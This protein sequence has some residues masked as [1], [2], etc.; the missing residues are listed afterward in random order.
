MT[1][2]HGVSVPCDPGSTPTLPI[3]F[4]GIEV[5]DEYGWRQ[6]ILD[7]RRDFTD[8]NWHM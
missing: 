3:I 5:K 7:G 2:E 6:F 1:Q 8:N 4:C